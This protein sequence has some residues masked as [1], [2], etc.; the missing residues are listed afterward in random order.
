MG[1][2]VA[3]VAGE[4][5]CWPASVSWS[6]LSV[7]SVGSMGGVVVV[8]VVAAAVVVAVAAAAA[9]GS[10][11]CQQHPRLFGRRGTK[12]DDHLP[13]VR[14]QRDVVAPCA[15]HVEA[16]PILAEVPGV[17][18][19][20]ASLEREARRREATSLLVACQC[21]RSQLDHSPPR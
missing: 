13:P 4:V 12:V 3:V 17:V 10:E 16:G 20:D 9:G 1:V 15:T 11:V 14:G 6:V 7:L 18:L 2:V 19:E 21:L 5:C 8:V